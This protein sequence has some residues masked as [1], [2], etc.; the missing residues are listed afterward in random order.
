[1]ESPYWKRNL[2]IC[3][4]GSFINIVAMTLL[5]PYLPLYVEQL[6]VKGHAAIAQWSGIAYGM[7]FLAAA[8]VAPLWGRVADR[9]GSKPNLI[10]ASLGMTV[11][12]C[13]IGL[14]QNIEQLVVLRLL[15]GLAGG[16]TSGS[17]VIVAAQT[18]KKHSAWALG[19]LSSAIM[20]GSLVG[21][22]IGGI[23]PVLMGIRSTFSGQC[24]Y[25]CQSGGHLPV[26]QGRK[27]GAAKAKDSARG[28]TW[29]LVQDRKVVLAMLMTAALLM[30]ANMSIEPIITVYVGQ[31]V[32]D[33]NAVTFLSG[34]VMSA[35]ALGSVLSASQLGKLADRIGS[36]NIVIVCLL[37][38]ALLLIPQ[39]FVSQAWQLIALRFFMGLALGGLLPSLTALIRQSVPDNIVGRILGYSTS[40]QYGGQVL[41][42]I[43]GGF[44][45]GQIG[46]RYVFLGTSVLLFCGAIYNWS[47]SLG[48]MRF[49]KQHVATNMTNGRKN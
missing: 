18:E 45:G 4:F 10:R 40:A 15:V 41:G 36:G 12:M 5:L 26:D 48:T 34:L 13:L 30:F 39:A 2:L 49:G 21:P 14:A 20:A 3:S 32:A 38:S 11:S 44:V 8:L 17:Y 42:P 6:G 19:I 22:L 25:R 28:S 7:T 47:I 29:S 31:L 33:V 37:A 16:Y 43:L 1:M 46:M 23:L 9:Y 35:A 24:L 27:E